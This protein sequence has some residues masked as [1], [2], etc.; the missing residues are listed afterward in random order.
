MKEELIKVI[1]SH[2]YLDGDSLAITIPTSGEA[3]YL[4]IEGLTPYANDLQQ[5][6]GFDVFDGEDLEKIIKYI[7]EE[8]Y[9]PFDKG[10][11]FISPEWK[12]PECGEFIIVLK[13][14]S[15]KSN[16]PEDPEE[17]DMEIEFLGKL[18]KEVKL[19]YGTI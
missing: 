3:A 17:W 9:P 11:L 12:K 7:E 10:Q 16:H 6:L 5:D 8:Q 4:K 1:W 18:G 13:V 19:V 15:W 14:D 2:E